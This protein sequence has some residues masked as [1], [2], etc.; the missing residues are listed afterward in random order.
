MGC[1]FEPGPIS[2]VPPVPDLTMRTAFRLLESMTTHF[3]LGLAEKR[4][5]L[6]AHRDLE[7]LAVRELQELRD[8][9]RGAGSEQPNRP[10]V[11]DVSKVVCSRLQSGIIE[12]QVPAEILQFIAQRL[13]LGPVIPRRL[14]RKKCRTAREPLAEVAARNAP[15]H[16]SALL[17]D[18]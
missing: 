16:V 3:D 9:L 15:L 17:V 2:A 1:H 6:A 14:Q 11:H 12:I 7:S 10:L 8:I 18:D 13:R 5:P 4:M